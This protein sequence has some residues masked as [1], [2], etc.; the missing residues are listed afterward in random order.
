MHQ[1]SFVVYFMTLVFSC[2]LLVAESTSGREDKVLLKKHLTEIRK[3]VFW[4]MQQKEKMYGNGTIV[5]ASR[6][7]NNWRVGN[8]TADD[9]DSTE[10]KS[11]LTFAAALNITTNKLDDLLLEVLPGLKTSPW[12]SEYYFYLAIAVVVILS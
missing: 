9:S 8:I 3:H 4:V 6:E 11:N 1:N 7:A 5:N 12:K 2:G 10:K